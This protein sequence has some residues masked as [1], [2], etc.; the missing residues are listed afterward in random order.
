MAFCPDPHCRWRRAG[1]SSIA[2]SQPLSDSAFGHHCH[3]AYRIFVD[4]VEADG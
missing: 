3:P 1:Q 2:L 4:H